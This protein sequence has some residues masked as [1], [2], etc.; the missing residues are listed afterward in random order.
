MRKVRRAA[1]KDPLLPVTKSGSSCSARSNVFMTAQLL[2]VREVVAACRKAVDNQ[3]VL[4]PCEKDEKLSQ[5]TTYI[6][7]HAERKIGEKHGNHH[8]VC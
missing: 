8:A 1:R 3:L 4:S 2:F 7:L 5:G 6:I